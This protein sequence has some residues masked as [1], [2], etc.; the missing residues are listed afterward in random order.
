M[1]KDI[2]VLT[3]EKWM[4]G[5]NGVFEREKNSSNEELIDYKANCTVQELSMFL[6]DEKSLK[7]LDMGCGSGS[8]S[9]YLSRFGQVTGFD[10]L[11]SAVEVAKRRAKLLDLEVSFEV[12]DLLTWKIRE[13][14]F[15]VIV[16]IQSLQYLFDHTIDKIKEI[17]AG[18]KPGGIF[19]YSG[20][21]LPHFTTNPPIRFVTKDEMMGLLEGWI[22]F[23]MGTKEMMMRPDDVRGYITVIA[24]KTKN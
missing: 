20:N 18:I 24:Q 21:I 7:I 23:S 8:E 12:A 10:A 2:K 22:I 15:D 19:V 11:S 4:N 13:K 6:R 17:L 3:P 5:W 16:A 1:N 14:S 9:C